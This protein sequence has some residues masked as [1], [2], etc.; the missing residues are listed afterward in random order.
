MLNRTIASFLSAAA[1][2]V[3]VATSSEAQ[4]VNEDILYLGQ[5]E[6]FQLFLYPGMN[7]YDQESNRLEAWI[8][9]RSLQVDYMIG[10]VYD[11]TCSSNTSYNKARLVTDLQGNVVDFTPIEDVKATED[12]F[13]DTSV[14]AYVRDNYCPEP[15]R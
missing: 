10:H 11:I 6:S 2:P 4:A 15:V 1:L 7:H 9:G 8:I 5:M 14:L 12:T 3:L 13:E